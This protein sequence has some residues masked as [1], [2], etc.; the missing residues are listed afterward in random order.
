MT[1]NY[2]LSYFF[3]WTFSYLLY[4]CWLV[5]G[6]PLTR[7]I[8][9]LSFLV[10]FG[11]FSLLFFKKVKIP[12][13]TRRFPI[14][15]LEQKD[16]YFIGAA[17]VCVLI[18]IYPAGFLPLRTLSDEPSHASSGIQILGG[19]SSGLA[20]SSFKFKLLQ[21]LSR[22]IILIG[23][24]IAIKC[25][26]W[27]SFERVSAKQKLLLLTIFVLFFSH[28]LF[29]F[30]RN[31]P[32]YAYLYKPPPLS[33][34]VSLAVTI[35]GGPTVFWARLPSLVFCILS[36]ALIYE[37]IS[38]WGHRDL[39]RI[40]AVIFLF[41][42]NVSYYACNATLG[43][44]TA[45]LSLLPLYFLMRFLKSKDYSA[46]HWCFFWAAA[47]FL[48][49]RPLLT[50]EAYLIAILIAYHIF[51]ERIFLKK[52]F[53][54][55]LFS[56]GVVLPFIVT[57]QFLVELP[58]DASKL[59]KSVNLYPLFQLEKLS[60]CL[61]IMPE[62]IT[63]VGLVVFCAGLLLFF[64]RRPYF[65]KFWPL[66][67]GFLCWYMALTMTLTGQSPPF[68]RWQLPL[69]PFIAVCSAFCFRF[70]IGKWRK[71][72]VIILGGYLLLMISCCTFLRFPA[73]HA[74][75]VLYRTD[76]ERPGVLGAFLP[77]EEIIL[78]MKEHLPPESK[79]M[80]DDF[81]DPREFYSFKHHLNVEWELVKSQN[82]LLPGIEGLYK[83]AKQAEASYL[84]LP[85]STYPL[86]IDKS[87]V[88]AVFEQDTTYFSL[89]KVF[90][91]PGGRVALFTVK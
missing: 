52:A 61:R 85:E 60:S 64:I 9:L 41:F 37:M 86:H 62:Q 48:W 40:A 47:G 76:S 53:T 46:L 11:V 59:E 83:K 27:E 6:S 50:G 54:C 82:E 34:W 13:A 24:I 69:Y 58:I 39:A 79:V 81:P 77:Y 78:H 57:G 8:W 75:Y 30:L 17:I 12:D 55:W 19:V 5:P 23:T 67:I 84:F 4:P 38:L 42:P 91:G 15:L 26:P 29:F 72:G 35:L 14:A 36:S 44:G 65:K 87:V 7:Y 31:A 63:F 28:I 18:H 22:L 1:Y 43:S 51:V 56:M 16:W 66:A 70:L 2:W 89:V 3:L 21:W 25:K 74:E 32:F 49:K 33:R 68:P 20:Y 71:T 90:S 88:N 80:A 45:F 73:L 10:Y